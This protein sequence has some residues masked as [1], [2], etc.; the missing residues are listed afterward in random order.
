M[1]AAP[2]RKSWTRS[3][4]AT[5]RIFTTPPASIGPTRHLASELG[6]LLKLLKDEQFALE[7]YNRLL[8]ETYQN[9][10]GKSSSSAEILRQCVSH[11]TEATA[12]TMN[13]GKERAEN[14]SLKSFEMEVIRQE[15][16]EYKRIANTDSLTRLAN[17]RAFDEKLAAIYNSEQQRSSHRPAD[18][19]H[20]PF[21]EGQRQLRS[22]GRRQDPG[23]RRHG[24][25]RQSAPRR[26]RRA[27]RRRGI[28]HH[29][30]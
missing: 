6:D 25:P 7:N 23:H 19:R 27:H 8:D 3:A 4:H 26:L 9:I 12:D 5:S 10:T 22:S 30:R 20:R 14:V 24:H 17:R 13:Q 28:C 2:P 16:D 15:L 1:A 21:Q 18:R 29:P 11:L